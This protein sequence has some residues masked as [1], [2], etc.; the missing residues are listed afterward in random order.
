LQSIFQQLPWYE[1]SIAPAPLVRAAASGLDVSA[2]VSRLNQPLPLVR[3]QLLAAKA[4]E[5]CQEVKSLGANLLAAIEKQD[6]ESL[7]LLRAQH[8]SAI[9]ALAEVVKY[10]QWQDAIKSRQAV[11]YSLAT[12]V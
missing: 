2:I 4:A 8:E 1:A 10:S 6:N 12:M 7:S 5:I 9:L 11:E 3:F